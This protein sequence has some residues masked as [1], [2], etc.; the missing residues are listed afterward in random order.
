MLGD[1]NVT[2]L[3]DSINLGQQK[4]ERNEMDN[5]AG[6]TKSSKNIYNILIIFISSYY[7]LYA[8]FLR[9]KSND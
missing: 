1:L 6:N 8:S 4:R 9:F 5:G 2:D 3:V 7:K